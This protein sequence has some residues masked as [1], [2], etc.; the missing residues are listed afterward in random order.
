[1]ASKRLAT[2]VSVVHPESNDVVWL[3][4]GD[5]VPSWAQDLVTNPQAFE[6]Y[7][8]PIRATVYTDPGETAPPEPED[9]DPAAPIADLLDYVGDDADRARAVLEAERAKGDGAR[10]TLVERLEAVTGAGG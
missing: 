8:E 2:H 4:P 5:T 7:T 9:F 10:R 1:M 3:Q 6:G